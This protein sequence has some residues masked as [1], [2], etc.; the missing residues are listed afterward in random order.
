VDPSPEAV[1]LASRRA[2]FDGHGNVRFAVADMHDVPAPR[3]FDAVVGRFVMMFQADQVATLRRLASYVRPGG[4]LILHEMD[5]ARGLDALP[6]APMWEQVVSIIRTTLIR[7]EIDLRAGM[8]LPITFRD[9]GIEPLGS[10]YAAR[11]QSALTSE[12]FPAMAASM[13]RLLP[14]AEEMGIVRPGQ[15]P[16]ER[17]ADLLREESVSLG[18]VI[19]TPVCVGVWGRVAV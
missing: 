19:T 7:C 18:T 12:A 10:H 17:L 3:A 8:R 4:L 9:A 15:I 14:A 6:S 5:A 11:L 13:R 2:A 16:I 1:D